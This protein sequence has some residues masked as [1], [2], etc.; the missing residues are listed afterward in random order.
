MDILLKIGEYAI[1]AL[2]LSLI[3]IGLAVRSMP[4]GQIDADQEPVDSEDLQDCE[5]SKIDIRAFYT[6][7]GD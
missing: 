1:Y 7:W 2:F 6:K 4:I 5:V 3:V